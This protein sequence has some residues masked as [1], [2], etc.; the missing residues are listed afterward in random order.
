MNLF[1]PVSTI[2]TTQLYTV[3]TE[4]SLATVKEIFDN[5]R[6][7][8]VP[9][10]HIRQLV[11]IISKTDFENFMGG[12]SKHKDD[13]L[14]L[15]ARLEHTKASDIMVHRLAKLDSADR[16]NVAIEIFCKNMFHALPVVDNDELVGIVTPYDILKMLQAEKP[17]HPEDVYD[18]A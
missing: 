18:A 16:V 12:M 13:Q 4:D 5:H 2:M 15:K 14:I 17:V 10:V 11:G 8:H 3:S 7:H 6:L 9:V 1:A